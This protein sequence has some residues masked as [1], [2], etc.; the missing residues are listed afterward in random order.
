MSRAAKS[1]APHEQDVR[2]AA[3]AARATRFSAFLFAGVGK[4]YRR[5]AAFFSEAVDAAIALEGE[6]GGARRS[7]VY[8]IT[9]GGESLQVDETV[10]R[11]A[12][13]EEAAI[14][15]FFRRG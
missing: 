11:L 4:R 9:A 7:L 14:E 15:R 8:A 6:F 1:A 3:L 12:G 2:S 5:E 10:A 13:F